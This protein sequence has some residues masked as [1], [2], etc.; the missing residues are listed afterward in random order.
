V[1]LDPKGNLTIELGDDA[2]NTGPR[3]VVVNSSV[4]A[5]LSPVW[6]KLVKQ[7]KMVSFKTPNQKHLV[8]K[9]QNPNM[10]VQMMRVAHGDFKNLVHCLSF[11]EVIDLAV[12]CREYGMNKYLIPFLAG[13]TNPY[14][15]HILQPG[16]EQWLYAAWQFGYQEGEL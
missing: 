11:K 15:A 12:I 16:Y 8:I 7:S 6:E 1:F 10:H 9:D 4:V 13:W 14:R 2:Q 5:R 3:Y